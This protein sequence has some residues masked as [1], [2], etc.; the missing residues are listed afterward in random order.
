MARDGGLRPLFHKNMKDLMW[1]A[2]ETWAVTT[3][4]PDSWYLS[5]E[6]AGGWVEFKAAPNRPTP[7][8]TAFLSRVWRYQGQSWVAVRFTARGRDSLALW[9]GCDAAALAR[10]GYDCGVPPLARWEGGPR[11]WDWGEV[12]RLITRPS[13]TD[14]SPCGRR[15]GTA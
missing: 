14:A 8:Q 2:V 1:A 10:G 11:R 3:G 13:T 7:E 9:R 15:P 4:V 6:G 5:P 12:R